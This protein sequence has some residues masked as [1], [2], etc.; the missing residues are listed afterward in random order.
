[1]ADDQCGAHSYI[2]PGGSLELAGDQLAGS[3]AYRFQALDEQS[4]DTG[5]ELHHSTHLNTKTEYIW[6]TVYHSFGAV[7][8]QASYAYAHDHT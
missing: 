8:S 6:Y 5:N 2:Q 3:V 7:A 4:C 1:M